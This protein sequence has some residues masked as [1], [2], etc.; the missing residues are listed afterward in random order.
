MR[1]P[2]VRYDGS[3]AVEVQNHI[4]DPETMTE[5]MASENAV[6]WREAMQTEMRSLAENGTWD[7]V[8]LPPG[9]K[10]IPNKWVYKLKL[11]G[12]G[13]I[14]RFKA[15]LVVKGCSQ[16][17]GIDYAETFS[18]VVRYST[19]RFL[20]AIAAKLNLDIDQMDA[21]TAFLQGDLK[22]EV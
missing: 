17:K 12:N 14:D 2:V 6:N 3:N 20:V 19:I 11:N 1:N 4:G 18:P 13:Q 5:A 21:V 16:R 9:R 22:E 8:D 15:R 7:L 10:A